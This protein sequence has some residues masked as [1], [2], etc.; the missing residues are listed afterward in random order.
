M[1]EKKTVVVAG[2]YLGDIAITL[3][4]LSVELPPYVK[5]LDFAQLLEGAD[6]LDAIKAK[7]D[8]ALGE[9]GGEGGSAKGEEGRGR[10]RGEPPRG[11]VQA[12]L[13]RAIQKGKFLSAGRCLDMLGEREA[14]VEKYLSKGLAGVGKG[15]GREAARALVIAANLDHK[16]GIPLFQYSGPALHESCTSS[17]GSCVTRIEEEH[18]VLKAFKYLIESEKVYSAIAELSPEERRDLLPHVVRERDPDAEEFFKRLEEAHT[19]LGKIEQDDLKKLKATVADITRQVGEF[20]GSAGRLKPQGDE[21]RAVLDRAVR[22]AAG[23]AKEFA[24]AGAL[25]DGWQFRRLERRLEQL[26]E[27]GDDIKQARKALGE[28]GGAETALAGTDE[29]IARLKQEDIL[30]RVDEIEKQLIATQVTIL[31]RSVHSQE[32]WQYLRELSFKYPSS[33]LV[34]CLRHINDRWM[35]VPVWDAPVTRLLM[36]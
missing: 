5:D 20:A 17:T 2:V 26:L 19:E 24:D 16:D 18:A 8:E 7:V 10:G 21:A 11:L 27:S 9:M 36:Q 6:D 31:G 1:D 4:G 28:G 23:L 12:V 35:V 14:Y 3:A 29:L 13:E 22:T 34:C 33:P 15:E 30:K 32:H 25:V